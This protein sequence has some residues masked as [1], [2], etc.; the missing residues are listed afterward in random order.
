MASRSPARPL[1][2]RA[3][4]SLLAVAL[5]VGGCGN[6]GSTTGR[7]GVEKTTITVAS[8]PLLDTAGLHIAVEQ[9]FFEAE[10][11]RV[12]IQPVAQSIAALPALRNGQIDVIAGGNYVTF[13][14]AYQQGTLKLKILAPA[15]SQASRFMRVLV[16]PDSPIRQPKDLEGRTVAVNILNNIQSL[17]LNEVL[18]AN[19]VDPAK[20]TYRAVPFTLM[21]RALANHDVDAVDTGEPFG[22]VFQQKLG[23]R[24]VVD[25]GG[26]PVTGLPVAGYVSTQDF[27]TR[28]PRTAAAFKRAIEKAQA[29][30]SGDRTRVEGVLPGYAHVD[31]KTATRLTLPGYPTSLDTAPLDKLA[32]LML[33]SGLLKN[34]IAMG[35]VLFRPAGS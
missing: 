32:G 34:R 7:N 10:G 2:G 28:Y 17:T 3:A 35:D 22:T 13:L 11:L 1:T 27:V 26:A 12:K 18:K 21:D 19:H 6:P 20:V 30:A 4:L 8:L 29:L 33:D 15:S 14:Q 23:A 9:K 24:L 5:V 16:L 31:A 25:G